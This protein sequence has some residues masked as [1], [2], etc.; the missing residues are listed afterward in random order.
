TRTAVPAQES[1]ARTHVRAGAACRSGVLGR[2]L[3]RVPAGA[4]QNSGESL[5][6]AAKRFAPTRVARLLLLQ[7]SA[8]ISGTKQD[9][10]VGAKTGGAR[11]R[12]RGVRRSTAA[13]ATV[14]LAVACSVRLPTDEDIDG[15]VDAAADAAADL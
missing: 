15:A 9:G 4:P 6:H 2:R 12:A 8:M 14:L 3:G 10:F 13:L 5:V 1:R 7:V 11:R